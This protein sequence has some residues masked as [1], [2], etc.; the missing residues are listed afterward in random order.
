M[1]NKKYIDFPEGIYDPSKILLQADPNTGAL[2]KLT[3]GSIPISGRTL[4]FDFS[5][6]QSIVNTWVPIAPLTIPAGTFAKTGD[7]IDTVLSGFQDTL[8]SSFDFKFLFAGLVFMDNT[9]AVDNAIQFQF[10]FIR[11]GVDSINGYGFLIIDNTIVDMASWGTTGINFSSPLTY[12]FQMRAHANSSIGFSNRTDTLFA[13]GGTSIIFAPTIETLYTNAQLYQWASA[14]DKAL[15]QCVISQNL[16]S[17]N[18]DFLKVVQA[19]RFT[20]TGTGKTAKLLLAE[21]AMTHNSATANVS[22]WIECFIVRQSATTMLLTWM[23]KR[24]SAAQVVNIQPGLALDWSQS[25][26]LLSAC[27]NT[28]DGAVQLLFQS[29]ELHRQVI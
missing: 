29:I 24:S 7:R 4:H 12:D 17:V 10:S 6:Y 16:L 3:F 8:T 1:A 23:W 20:G 2:Q 26:T 9:Y 22:I 14:G 28:G 11:S 19:W 21:H 18:G 15:S 25:H 27:T 13:A 5:L